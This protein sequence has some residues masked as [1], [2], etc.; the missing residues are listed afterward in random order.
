[1]FPVVNLPVPLKQSLLKTWEP[2]TLTPIVT[3]LPQMLTQDVVSPE[4]VG[5]VTHMPLSVLRPTDVE[6]IAGLEKW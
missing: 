5:H 1:M 3:E 4:S 2:L 6:F